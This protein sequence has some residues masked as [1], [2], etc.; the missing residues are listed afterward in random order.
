LGIHKLTHLFGCESKWNLRGRKRRARNHIWIW[1][2]GNRIINQ[3]NRWII[4]RHFRRI[5]RSHDR[6]RIKEVITCEI[7][8]MFHL[9]LFTES[10]LSQALSATLAGMFGIGRIMSEFHQQGFLA[11]WRNNSSKSSNCT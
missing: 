10:S 1:L 6:S 4:I 8:F 7:E 9:I 2:K 5:R 3:R 11:A